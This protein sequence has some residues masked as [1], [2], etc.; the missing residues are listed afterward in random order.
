MNITKSKTKKLSINNICL[1]AIF[2]ALISVFAQI[3][4]PTPYGVHFTMQT[5]GIVLSGTILGKKL[6][7]ITVIIYILL[8]IIGIPVFAGFNSGIGAI[9]GKSAGFIISFPIMSYLSGLGYSSNKRSIYYI[10]LALA[11]MTNYIF[12]LT[13]FVII[14]R[15]D[16][17]T[18]LMMLIVPFVIPD[19][20][21]LIFC[22]VTTGRIHSKYKTIK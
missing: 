1:M 19:I 5:F 13:L 12:G 6:G 15:L 17:F 16:I 9:M 21:K 4:I 18:S 7:P 3:N 22:V 14:T 2:V 10:C 11:T 8:G 20:L